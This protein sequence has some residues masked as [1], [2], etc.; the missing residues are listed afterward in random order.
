MLTVYLSFFIVFL[1]LI[2]LISNNKI[3]KWILTI[4]ILITPGVFMATHGAYIYTISLCFILIP[5][6]LLYNF[7]LRSQLD[8]KRIIIALPFLALT[9]YITN[10]ASS[11]ISFIIDE[12]DILIAVTLSIICAF[13]SGI[14][15][16]LTITRTKGEKLSD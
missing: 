5:I 12:T 9:I 13:I 14:G 16:I 6:T 8:S 3:L 11:H 15:I 10:N 1:F 4:L 2:W 7:D